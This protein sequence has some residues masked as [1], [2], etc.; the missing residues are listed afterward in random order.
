MSFEPLK[1]ELEA[2]DQELEAAMIDLS[3]TTDRVDQ[4]LAEFS[5]G[6]PRRP[7]APAEPF[8]VIQPASEPND[9]EA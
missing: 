7:A 3:A 2:I 6:V 1:K 4:L 9:D 5:D 8:E